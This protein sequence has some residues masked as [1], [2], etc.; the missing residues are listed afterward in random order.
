MGEGWIYL[1][2][3]LK[4]SIDRAAEIP[5]PNLGFFALTKSEVCISIGAFL[6]RVSLFCTAFGIVVFIA[7]ASAIVESKAS[8]LLSMFYLIELSVFALLGLLDSMRSLEGVSFSLVVEVSRRSY[9]LL[10]DLL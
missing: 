7:S 4:F 1:S 6:G 5:C 3:L 8:V 9:R 2:W 10:V